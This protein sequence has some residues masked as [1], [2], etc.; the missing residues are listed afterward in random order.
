MLMVFQAFMDE[1]I[2]ANATFVLGGYIADTSTWAKFA[3]DWGEILPLAVRDKR[4][5]L[6]FKMSEMAASPERMANVPAFY[7][8]I[9]RHDLFSLSCRIDISELMR[10]RARISVD[11]LS[12]DWGYTNNPYS[13][14]FRCLMDM[15]HNNRA[16]LD[17]IVPNEEKIDFIF[18]KRAEKKAIDGVWEE[19]LTERPA[20]SKK[21]Y[22]ANPR[23]EDDNEF[24]ALQAA[25]LWAWW[26]REWY[27]AG[28]PEKMET[29][30]FGTWKAT[31]QPKGMAISFTE[32]QL[33]EFFVSYISERIEARR[34]IYDAKYSPRPKH[35]WRFFWRWP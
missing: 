2:T 31:K 12:I 30:D 33:A 11:N 23:F 7:R 16:M 6:R 15:F 34:P 4:G 29:C 28:T 18:D 3:K 35:N 17:S 32:D 27:E 1:S 26:V 10:A 21:Y 14:A 25:D 13:M 5:R 8:V 22:G 9:E 24:L 20:E 19:Y